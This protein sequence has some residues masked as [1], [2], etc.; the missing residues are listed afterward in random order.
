[1]EPWHER[2]DF[3]LA[4]GPLIF[5]PRRWEEA[6]PQVDRLVAL[7]GLRPP[8]A[9][10]DLCCGPGRHS[11]ELARRGFDVVGVDRTA[12][13]LDRAKAVARAEGL[14][15]EFVE[16]DVREYCRPDSFDVALNLFT[17]F[18]YFDDAEDDRRVLRNALRSL[19]PGGRLVMDLM[20]KEVLARVLRERVWREENG[21]L[22]LE[23]CRPSAD[24]GRV[25]CRWILIDGTD[26]REFALSHRLYSA[27]ELAGLLRGCGFEAVRVHGDLAGAPYDHRADR[28]VAVAEKG[29][30]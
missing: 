20:G 16:A 6:G 9:V 27:A 5:G 7:L 10:L 13:Y 19:R 24:W 29:R 25:D 3:W 28:L 8:A 1:M 18:G 15:A 14:G 17:S 30:G 11:L 4:T 26:R 2:D 22:F 21:T 12:G 23:E